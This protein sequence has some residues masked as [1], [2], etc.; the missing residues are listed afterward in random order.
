MDTIWIQ[1]A[2]LDSDAWEMEVEIQITSVQK[3]SFAYRFSYRL[4]KTLYQCVRSKR[5]SR[6][7]MNLINIHQFQVPSRILFVS[8][9]VGIVDVE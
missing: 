7:L 2:G 8:Q 6:T 1:D 9:A 4:K 3:S 5:N